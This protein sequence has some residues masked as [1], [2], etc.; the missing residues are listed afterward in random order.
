MLR[1]NTMVK[2][3][4]ALW[5]IL[6]VAKSDTPANCTYEDIR[7]NWIFYETE[8][9]GDANINCNKIGK[10]YTVH[11]NINT[12]LAIAVCNGIAEQKGRP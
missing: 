10:T 7:G 6:G 4:L 12:F 1:T 9:T 11:L 3:L 5:C 2:L 8:R